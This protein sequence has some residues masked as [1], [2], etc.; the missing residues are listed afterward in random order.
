VK[1]LLDTHVLLW[2]RHESSL[3]RPETRD[4]FAGDANELMWSAASTWELGIK[5]QLGKLRLQESLA[6]FVT[7][8]LEEENLRG[9][10]IQHAHV[11]H[12]S[13]LPLIHRD[14]FDRLLVA[15]AMVEGVP[16]VTGD[17]QL[18]AYGVECIAA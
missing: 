2:W 18:A 3:L 14:P 5:S 13:G 17:Q 11:I 10:P 16:L 9:L 8:V 4:L 1:A 15:Q 7:R 6:S 12:A